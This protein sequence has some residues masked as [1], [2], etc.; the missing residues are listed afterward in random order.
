MNPFVI[1]GHGPISTSMHH[2]ICA[3]RRFV[4]I[5]FRIQVLF[6]NVHCVV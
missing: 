4:T 2:Y 3:Q 5:L 1:V 6:F